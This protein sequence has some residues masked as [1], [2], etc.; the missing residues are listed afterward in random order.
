[1][2][3]IKSAVS[4]PIVGAPATNVNEA[5]TYASE[6]VN[7]G[8]LRNYCKVNGLTPAADI[9]ESDAG[10]PIVIFVPNDGSENIRVVISRN[11]GVLIPST[12]LTDDLLDRLRVQ[13]RADKGLII[14]SGG[15][16]LM[17]L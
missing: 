17:T 12:G 16:R 13:E 6:L 15:L 7:H 3:D 9:Y 11:A 2:S 8:S 10:N 4:A 1:M 14:T 5:P